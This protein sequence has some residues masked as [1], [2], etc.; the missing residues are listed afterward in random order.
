ME[1]HGIA[2]CYHEAADEDELSFDVSPMVYSVVIA[3]VVSGRQS[4]QY[5]TFLMVW[6]S[7]CKLQSEYIIIQ[8]CVF[9]TDLFFFKLAP[10]TAVTWIDLIIGV[11]DLINVKGIPWGIPCCSPFQRMGSSALEMLLTVAYK[12]STHP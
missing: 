8:L 5:N 6:V 3:T 7:V 1:P 4:V 12:S 2:T 11:C 10:G 9:Y